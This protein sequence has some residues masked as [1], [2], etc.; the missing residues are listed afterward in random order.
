[1]STETCPPS[2]NAGDVI[3]HHAEPDVWVVASVRHSGDPFGRMQM[4]P[5]KSR[6]AALAAA[7]LVLASG[8]RIYIHHHDAAEWECLS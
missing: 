8:H 5:K 1:M 2:T 3:V 6:D 4:L 7:R